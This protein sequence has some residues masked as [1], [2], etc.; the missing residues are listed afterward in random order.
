MTAPAK[1]LFDTDFGRGDRRAGGSPAERQAQIAEAEARGYRN[2]LA[3]GRDAARQESEQQLAQALARAADGIASLAGDMGAL[4]ARLESEAVQVA[5]AVGSRL[6]NAL[7]AR[8]PFAEV[9]ALALEC[10]RQL[11][12]A[13]HLV[14]RVNDRFFEP[15]RAK[16]QELA[17]HSGFQGK[18][19][20]L[21]DPEID[22]GDC[23]IEW[24]DGGMARNRAQTAAAIADA[25]G[26]YLAVRR[27]AASSG[28]QKP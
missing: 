12:G 1:F 2:G 9:Q 18:V 21:A 3:A 15:A 20:V 14:V 7:L 4:E 22:Q 13:P 25:V 10:F 26:R 19:V 24:A 6:S 5:V 17:A 28:S 16:L 11:V 27:A 23:R 8:E